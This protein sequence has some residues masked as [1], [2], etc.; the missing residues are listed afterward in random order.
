M[1]QSKSS[2]DTLEAGTFNL[3]T[4]HFSAFNASSDHSGNGRADGSLPSKAGVTGGEGSTG[5][6]TDFTPLDPPRFVFFDDI[7]KINIE[8][9]KSLTFLI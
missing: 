5:E 1:S 2:R 8:V 4:S 7:K 3:G 6:V 9:S